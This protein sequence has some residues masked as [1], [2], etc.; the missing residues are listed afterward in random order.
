M[1]KAALT[2]SLSAALQKSERQEFVS[3]QYKSQRNKLILGFEQWTVLLD[4][5]VSSL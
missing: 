3:D 2:H 5:I 4:P 1:R